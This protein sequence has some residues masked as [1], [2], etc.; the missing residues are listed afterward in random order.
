MPMRGWDVGWHQ[1]RC[2]SPQLGLGF[3]RGSASG[4]RTPMAET[5]THTLLPALSTPLACVR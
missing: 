4:Y 1:L 5:P 2:L 3:T